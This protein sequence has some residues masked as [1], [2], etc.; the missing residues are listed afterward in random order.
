MKT[1]ETIQAVISIVLFA[2]CFVI[3]L[4]FTS[5]AL[6][7][8]IPGWKETEETDPVESVDYT[9]SP[10]VPYT[11]AQDTDPVDPVT[12]VEDTS[13]QTDAPDTS[14]DVTS[15]EGSTAAE[16]E[17]QTPVTTL[18]ETTLPETTARPV[19]QPVGGWRTVDKDYFADALFIGD[20]RTEGICL[21]S[22]GPL[23]NAVFFSGESWTC[24]HAMTVRAMAKTGSNPGF[25]DAANTRTYYPLGEYTLEELLTN[26]DF[27]FKKIYIMFGLNE[28]GT[29]V[30]YIVGTVGSMITMCRTLCPDAIIFAE[31][32]LYMTEGFVQKNAASGK[33]YYNN[34]KL[35]Q[36]N[37]GIKKFADWKYV[38]YIDI[39]ELMGDGK[40]NASTQYCT[41][42]GAHP[43]WEHYRTWA[44]WFYTKGV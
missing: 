13:P 24:G 33:G 10:Y 12:S 44:E 21:G 2:L 9:Y 4:P 28:I 34:V 18:P 23:S 25:V 38:F 31:A 22:Y 11:P 30:D 7:E 15:G 19:D 39:N 32:N 5:S 29:P 6:L 40:G 36:I 14:D 20:S 8:R 35:A 41:A 26:G 37:E 1:K 27:K 43:K 3:T 16:T 42:G 17:T